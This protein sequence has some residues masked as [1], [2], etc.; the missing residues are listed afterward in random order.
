[1]HRSGT[2]ALT[3]ILNL[4]GLPLCAPE[5]LYTEW[6]NPHGHWES[7]TVIDV[8]DALLK[9]Y[10]G[11]WFRPPTLRAGWERDTELHALARDAGERFPRTHPT[12]DWVVKDPRLC[13]TFPFWR[14]IIRPTAIVLATRAPAPVALSIFRRD[15][16]RPRI[17]LALWERYTRAAV[18]A[19]A[20]FPTVVVHHEDILLDPHGGI[21]KLIAGLADIGVEV[22]EPSAAI[23]S[24]DSTS[25][26]NGVPRIELTDAQDWLLSTIGNLQPSYA[27]FPALGL[28]PETPRLDWNFRLPDRIAYRR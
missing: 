25:Q 4:L 8:N 28:G 14:D 1:M 9:H 10:G 13:L 7:Q 3:R 20:G 16:L 2:S 26:S 19:C 27:S 18:E 24:I 5:D 17:G 6:D 23:D 11:S 22:G 12:E 15:R 21:G